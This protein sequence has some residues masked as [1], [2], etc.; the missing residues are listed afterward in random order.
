MEN[1][2]TLEHNNETNI[3]NE[4]NTDSGSNIDTELDDVINEL[5]INEQINNIEIDPDNLVNIQNN[6]IYNI[7]N[8][9]INNV[10]NGLIN[11]IEA[12]IIP[13]QVVMP[14]NNDNND[15]NN[16]NN[17]NNNDENILNIVNESMLMMDQYLEFCNDENMLIYMNVEILTMIHEI[18]NQNYNIFKNRTITFENMLN[19]IITNSYSRLLEI[20][21]TLKD[22]TLHIMTY[23]SYSA[24]YINEEDPEY[25]NYLLYY[26]YSE[27]KIYIKKNLLSMLFV[28]NFENNIPEMVD[29]RSV[30]NEEGLNNLITTSY[31][32]MNDEL[33]MI[34]D[35][36]SIC[37]E[38]YINSSEKELR[39]LQ[40]D[41]AFC[42]ECID[43]WLL[44][45]SHKCP[46]CRMEMDDHINI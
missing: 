45:Y 1:N 10:F 7:F 37:R 14:D 36:C 34:N 13:L 15:N 35:H 4:T 30:L 17:D 16:D 23:V 8:I 33:K 28:R 6:N 40:C 3:D 5:Y 19:N 39:L 24:N 22:S 12:N 44:E 29:V 9:N 41:H 25:N 26:N 42:R 32:N 18:F 11:N 20:G 2:N 46:N 21:E 31:N 38:S 27:S 43:P